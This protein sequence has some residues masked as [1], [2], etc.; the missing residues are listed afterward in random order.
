[1]TEVFY[2]EYEPDSYYCYENSYVL[3]NKLNITDAE[4]LKDAEREI[5]SLRT[6]QIMMEKNKDKFDFKYLK[7][8]HHILLG[9]IYEWAGK[10]RTVNIAKGDQF[11]LCQYIDEQMTELFLKLEKE[12]YLQ[13]CKSKEELGKRLA[14]YLSEINAIHA[15][16]EGNGRTQRLFIGQLANSV[17]YELDYSKIT[18]EDMI[19]ASKKAFVLDYEM[20]E[21]LI[22]NALQRK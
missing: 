2:Y 9:D 8:L 6:A 14:Y 3:I 1:M 19:Q 12:N 11:C 21:Q 7:K 13:D 22:T 16:R 18:S 10:I 17:D 4:K 15:F 20:M 5:T